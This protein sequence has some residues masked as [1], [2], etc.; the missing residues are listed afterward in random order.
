M[1]YYTIP[2]TILIIKGGVG[3]G[4]KSIKI[5]DLRGGGKREESVRI[6]TPGENI[7]MAWS[8]CGT[9]LGVGNK[10]DRINFV[11]TRVNKIFKTVKFSVEV[12]HTGTGGGVE[13]YGLY[14]CIHTLCVYVTMMAGE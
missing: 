14:T 3:V 4:D 9:F 10:E 11:D 8:P 13:L 12:S 2:S 6:P 7:N 1:Q 5:W